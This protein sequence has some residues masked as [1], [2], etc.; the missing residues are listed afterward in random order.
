MTLLVGLVLAGMTA[1]A[2]EV[3]YVPGWNRTAETNGLAFARCT[4]TY[5]NATCRFWGWDGDRLWG[6]AAT[7][8]DLAATR[9][10]DELAA[11]NAAFRAELTLVGHS[12]GGRLIAR[13]L[14][15]LAER[16]I[17][18]GQAVLLAPAIP[19]D[20]ADV[21]K[22]G[23]GSSDPVIVLVNPQDVVLKYVYKLAPGVESPSL[24]TNGMLKPGVNI[25]EYAVPPD[26][27]Q[28]TNIE[29]LW[30][31]SEKVKRLCNHLAAFY[32][33]EL[34]KILAGVPSE[35]AQVRVVQ[36]HVNLA[37]KTVDAG[38]WWDVMDTCGGWK[39]EK[40]RVTRHYRILD[41]SKRRVAWGRE[42]VMRASFE[43]L[44]R[45]LAD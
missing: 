13:T 15:R 40:N 20:D 30:G 9:L 38:I 45:Q 39:L 29:A 24:G 26:I 28:K 17:T 5:A 43:K 6:T 35:D 41:P 42:R 2:A 10:A 14:A 19:M 4:N 44:K 32:F 12:L 36:D 37:W 23:A 8:A 31:K 1:V 22:M 33:K 11:T 3:W 25:A 18:V 21:L 16:K 34:E 7:N 27:T